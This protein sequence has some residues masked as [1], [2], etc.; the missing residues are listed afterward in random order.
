MV[1]WEGDK[2]ERMCSMNE[3]VLLMEYHREIK[4]WI[5]GEGFW[6][7]ILLERAVLLLCTPTYNWET[8]TTFRV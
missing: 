6:L 2:Q 5:E 3:T 7:M 8:N 4:S 1:L